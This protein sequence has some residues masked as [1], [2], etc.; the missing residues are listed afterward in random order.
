VRA[1][2]KT[3]RFPDVPSVSDEQLHCCSPTNGRP[4]KD[5][6]TCV[7]RD[8]RGRQR[9]AAVPN[10]SAL[11]LCTATASWLPIA[12]SPRDNGDCPR[13]RRPPVVS[14]SAGC[15]P[16]AGHLQ[17][18]FPCQTHCQVARA[19]AVNSSRQEARPWR[20]WEIDRSARPSREYAGT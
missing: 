15:A 10:S 17:D 19:F 12:R 2:L 14:R 3:E 13:V 8:G 6:V 1:R 16:E 11:R 20:A 7:H 18:P 5:L 9:C 4:L